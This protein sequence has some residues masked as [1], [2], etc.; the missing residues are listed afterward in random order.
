MIF[1][2]EVSPKRRQIAAAQAVRLLQIELS[3]AETL[4]A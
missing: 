2:A 3:S 4:L 1:G